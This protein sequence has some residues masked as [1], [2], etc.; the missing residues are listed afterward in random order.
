MFLNGCTISDSREFGVGALHDTLNLV[1]CTFTNNKKNLYKTGGLALEQWTGEKPNP[2][3]QRTGVEPTGK[4]GGKT[5][6]EPTAPPPAVAPQKKPPAPQ[7]KPAPPPAGNKAEE[8][9]RDV[10]RHLP[11]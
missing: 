8:I 6:M 2:S 10:L 5:G 9:I 3:E 1:N 11:R 7:R 4:T